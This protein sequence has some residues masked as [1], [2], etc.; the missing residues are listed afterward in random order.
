VKQANGFYSY[1]GATDHHLKLMR[2]ICD[3][4]V[5]IKAAGGVRTLDDALRVRALGVSRI[6]ASATE[7]ILA[8][9]RARLSE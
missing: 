7:A 6:G 5:Q 3:P 9:A 8:E 4:S 2:E 1:A